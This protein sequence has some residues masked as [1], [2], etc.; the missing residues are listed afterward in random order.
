MLD[1][2]PCIFLLFLICF[3]WQKKKQKDL[4]MY[5]NFKRSLVTFIVTVT[6]LT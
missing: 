1:H 5:K 2:S 4:L 6:L 3:L